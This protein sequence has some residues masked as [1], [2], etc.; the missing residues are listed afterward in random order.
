M[1][2]ST[3]STPHVSAPPDPARPTATPWWRRWLA[4]LAIGLVLYAGYYALAEYWVY[5]HGDQNRFH[6][7]RT[8][9]PTSFDF[10][11]LGASHAMPLAYEDMNEQLQEATGSRIMNLAM[12]GGGP[13]PNRLILDY[14]LTRHDT[15]AVVYVVDSFAFYSEEWNE[16]RLTAADLLKA[17]LDPALAGEMMA[18]PWARDLLAGYLSGFAKMNDL[19]RFEPDVAEGETKFRDSYRP[20]EQIDRRRVEFL[21]PEAYPEAKVERY[22]EALGALAR[23]L[24]ARGSELLLLRPPVPERVRAMLPF[25]DR[26]VSRL[27]VFGHGAEGVTL[28]DFSAAVED[29]AMYYDTDHLNREGVLTWFD[30]GLV[31]VLREASGSR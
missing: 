3:L 10:A 9:P 26:F 28:H 12:E 8:T 29:E 11:V 15:E 23:D 16:D 7:V 27:E 18:R 24:R 31:D 2:D 21:Y 14:F 20:I 4:F 19:D 22:F 5:Q 30:A 1:N 6:A 17:P 13:L 25:E